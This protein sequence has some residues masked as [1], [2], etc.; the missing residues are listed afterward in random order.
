MS[1]ASL[2]RVFVAG[3]ALAVGLASSAY[4]ALVFREA[5]QD[6]ISD[7]LYAPAPPSLTVFLQG[8]GP[9]VKND[10]ESEEMAEDGE[11]QEE[12]LGAIQ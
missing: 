10:S 5:V 6:F 12:G 2:L 7:R 8:Y 1:G 9:I 11:E 4:Y 3:G